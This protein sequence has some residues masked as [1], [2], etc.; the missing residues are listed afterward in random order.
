V[1]G[2]GGLGAV[3]AE[4][5]LVEVGQQ[6]IRHVEIVDSRAHIITAIELLSPSNKES[7]EACVAWKRKR[8][9]YLRGGINLVEIDLLRGGCWTLPDRSLLKPVPP[10]HV[11]HYACVSRSPWAGEHEFYLLPL[12]QRL[13]AIRVP[14]RQPDPDAALDLQLLIDQCYDRGRYGSEI[15]YS[16]PPQPPLPGEEDAWAKEVLSAAHLG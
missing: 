7:G 14:L 1:L 6:V 8:F 3:V 16:R 10:G 13:P 4:P 5:V 15:D 11:W 2:Q 9:D 12:R